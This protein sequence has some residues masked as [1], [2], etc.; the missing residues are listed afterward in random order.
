MSRITA[1]L[2]ACVLFSA[3]LRDLFLELASAELFAPRWSVHIQD[4]WTRSVAR[5][6]PDIAVSRLQRTREIMD[7]EFPDAIV[8][9]YEGDISTLSLPDPDDR[10][11]LAAAIWPD[12]NG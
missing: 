12:E 4:E 7:R 2:D 6:R 9:G 10:H 1:V 11:V 8:T 5:Q 3:P